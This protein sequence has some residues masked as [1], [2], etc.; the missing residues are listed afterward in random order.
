MNEESTSASTPCNPLHP[1]HPSRFYADEVLSPGKSE[2]AASKSGLGS[3]KGTVRSS[4]G[5]RLDL[6]DLVCKV[7]L[8]LHPVQPFESI[9]TIRRWIYHNDLHERYL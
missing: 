9:G 5:A 6:Q 2:E 8:A 7:V 3:G 1:F 4:F